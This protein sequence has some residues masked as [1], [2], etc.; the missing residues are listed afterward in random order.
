MTASHDREASRFEL[1]TTQRLNESGRDAFICLLLGLVTLFCYWPA[2]SHQF[3]S[4]DDGHYLFDSGYVSK[5]LTW[6]GV[7][8]ALQ[9]GY[10]ANWHPLTWI[11]YMLDAQLYGMS[12]G[13]FHLT[14]VIFHIANSLLVFLLLKSMTRR[15]LLSAIAGALF[16]W[17]PLH[18]ESVAWVSERKDVLSTFFFLLTLFSYFRYVKERE[19][20]PPFPNKASRYYLLSLLLFMLALASKQMVVTLPCVLLLLDLWPLQRFS[21][22]STR[23]ES[24]SV[25]LVLVRE[26]LPF[27]VLAFAASAIAFAVQKAG[28]SVSSFESVPA[29]LRVA[30][31]LLAY[32]AY[33]SNSFW[34]VNLAA[35][36][37]LSSHFSFI[38]VA[39][40]AI[41]L[42]A[43]TVVFFLRVRQ[44]PFLLVGWLWFIGALVPVIGLIQIGSQS[45]ADRYMYIPAIG[46][47]IAV[48]WG[49]DALCRFWEGR[50]FLGAA[51]SGKP[52]ADHRFPGK[53]EQPISEK[54]RAFRF[55]ILAFPL[56]VA[57]AALAVCTRVQV[58]Y[59]HDSE[60]LFRHAVAAVPGNYLAYNGLGKALDD[61]GRKEEAVKAWNEALRLD[62]EYPEAQYNLGTSLLGQERV[63]E[64]FPHLAAAVK[65][66]P[67]NANAHE[68]LGNVYVKMGELAK[69][70]VEYAA[71][72]RLAPDNAVYLQVLGSVLVRQSK[73]SEADTVLADTLRLDPKS[74]DAHRNLGIVRINQGKR[75]E[76]LRLFAEAV[77]LQPGNSDNRF[78]LGLALLEDNQSERA[79]EQF[80][81][82]LRLNPKETRSHYRLAVALSQQHQVKE[83]IFH[84]H[85]ALR[86]TPE[87]PDAMC[88]L[89]RLLACAPEAELRDGSEA[90]TLAERA[91]AMTNNQQAA[92]LTTLAAAYA[93]TGRFKDAIITAQKAKDL[94]ANSGQNALAA[95]AGELLALCQSGRPLRE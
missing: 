51:E 52:I 26:K 33:I 37:P 2:R 17:H 58:G 76:A 34:P 49:L 50:A 44:Y 45:R 63:N 81:E 41:F 16:A 79:A 95:K 72:A 57:L 28:G 83:A 3:V 23:S 75:T 66:D 24:L 42:G 5:G 78:N 77:R 46:F 48:I 69:A 1:I 91:C 61:L 32:V 12:P 56:I 65:G 19:K 68:N 74:V 36:Y 80:A 20:C 35:V 59:W 82:C 60:K 43:V 25:G 15:V 87:F 84:Y 62:P 11:S 30:N 71:A 9:T 67:N 47:S 73:W 27:F 85:E 70:T 8:W 54:I 53:L 90:V 55:Q 38:G 4:F 39:G 86:L 94:A 29:Q 93:E 7:I 22:N 88:E 31:S 92:M 21:F 89:A 6:P 14:N 40:A 13:G 18:V 10:F 64:A